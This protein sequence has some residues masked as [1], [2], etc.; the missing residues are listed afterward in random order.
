MMLLIA[1]IVLILSGLIGF[2]LQIHSIRERN[3]STQ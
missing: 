3:L 2:V 1:G